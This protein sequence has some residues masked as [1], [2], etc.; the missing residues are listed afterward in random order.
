VG[1]TAGGNASED[2][3]EGGMCDRIVL[4]NFELKFMID[5]GHVIAHCLFWI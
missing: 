3:D 4:T 1:R 2:D 5:D